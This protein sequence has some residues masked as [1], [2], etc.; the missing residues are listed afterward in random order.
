MVRKYCQKFLIVRRNKLNGKI[1]IS[2]SKNTSLP[3]LAA[4]LLSGK[5]SIIS[6]VPDLQDIDTIKD[7]LGYLG[8]K[9]DYDN[10]N[11]VIIVASKY[12]KLLENI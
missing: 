10:K 8:A 11:K 4:T 3:I 6:N 7:V 1:E 2:G 5:I 9:I 12:N